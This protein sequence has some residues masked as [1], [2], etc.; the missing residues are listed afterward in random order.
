[1]MYVLFEGIDRAGKSTQIEL[2]KRALPDA[3]FTKEPGGT[4][5]GKRI[6]E[7]ILHTQNPT[8]LAEVFLFLAD[9]AEHIQKII[10]ANSNKLIIS[11]RGYISGIAYAHTKTEIP[12]QKLCWLNSIAM[13]KTLPHKI[14]LLTLTT[15]ELQRRLALHPL[16][17]IEKRGIEY[18]ISVQEIMKN[19]VIHSKIAHL[20]IDGAK[21]V[22]EIH[23]QI[24]A[25]IKDS[26]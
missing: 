15:E 17:N 26:Q 13:Q 23:Q 9:R 7:I 18:L 12:L 8:P 20:I 25:F 11:D 3:L 22:K 16:D 19:L 4:P 21:P 6:R 24:V 2:L 5:L 10:R 14:V 1:M